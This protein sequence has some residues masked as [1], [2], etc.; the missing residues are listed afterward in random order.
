MTDFQVDDILNST[1]EGAMET[2]FT[3]VPE[4]EWRGSC[5]KVEARAVG[6]QKDKIVMDVHWTINDPQVLE[7]TGMEAPSVRQSIFL[8]RN[9]AGGLDLGK[10]KNVALGKLREAVDQNG[11]TPWSPGMLVGSV[12]V[13]RV[14]HRQHE[15]NT[16]ADVK[17]V[18]HI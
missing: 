7:A 4:G 18:A 6:E 1:T 11:P 12:A 10:G 8:D 16:Y 13:V 5:S 15:G 14:A 17:A 9:L 2:S 3:P